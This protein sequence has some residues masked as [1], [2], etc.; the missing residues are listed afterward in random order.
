MLLYTRRRNGATQ[1]TG[2]LVPP[3]A[4]G[5][6]IH[7][8]EDGN[9]GTDSSL[10]EDELAPPLNKLQRIWQPYP[11]LTPLSPSV[12]CVPTLAHDSGTVILGQPQRARD[13][14]HH[15]KPTTPVQVPGPSGS[16]RALSAPDGKAS[17]GLEMTRTS[18][19]HLW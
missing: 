5:G 18:C 4:H 17:H 13:P 1:G 15:D 16:L 11:C 6:E 12:S 2:A 19:F 14:L 8:G 9:Q 3:G 7:R 10:V